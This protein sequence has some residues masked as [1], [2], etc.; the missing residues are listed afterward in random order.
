[1]SARS[2]AGVVRENLPNGL[3]VLVE[4][5]KEFS[6]VSVGVWVLIGSRDETEIQSGISHFIE[7]LVF[8]GTSRRTAKQIALEIDSLG[9]SLNAFTSKEFTCFYARV[10][11]ESLTQ[12]LDVLSD[13]TL[14]SLFAGDDLVK[15]K[16]VILQEI[17]MVEDTPDDLVHDLHCRE[18]WAGQGI[19]W[20]VLGTRDSLLAIGSGNVLDFHRSHYRPEQM[21]ITASGAVDSN[22]LIDR[23]GSIFGELEPG[24]S[25]VL[26]SAPRPTPGI[27][28]LEKP[29]EQI[30][31]CVGYNGLPAT[32]EKRYAMY[33]LNTL[34][35]GGMS[36]RLFQKIRE[37]QGLAYSVYS[38]HSTYQDA[39]L[40]T[41]YCGTSREG[42][43][44][45]LEIIREETENLAAERPPEE[46]LTIARQQLK[47]NLLLGL[48]STGNRMN[49]LAKN[50]IYFGR[51]VSPEEIAEGIDSVTSEQVRQLA[52]EL[53]VEEST[54]L[55]VI[56]PVSEEEVR[57]L[58]G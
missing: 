8:K 14:N 23:I 37:E 45:A 6:S 29:V 36:S 44:K 58:M 16:D 54:A 25:P 21:L 19:G 10:L 17:S 55:T 24:T 43:S 2:G 34:L 11:G 20:P 1:M 53:F 4:P 5:L 9:G 33:L 56:G 57:D 42:F 3:T 49:Q 26:R 15:E 40:H 28:V 32:H 41:I 7:H 48:E 31:F 12:A 50:E 47:G 52:S 51:Q 35:G 18:F 13:I 22:D 30:H 27:C 46:E 38:Y 39:G